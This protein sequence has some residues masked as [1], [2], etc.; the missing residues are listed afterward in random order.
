MTERKGEFSVNGQRETMVQLERLYHWANVIGIPILLLLALSGDERLAAAWWAV[1]VV[2]S[3]LNRRL[4][5]WVARVLGGL[6]SYAVALG[7]LSLGIA[8]ILLLIPL[9]LGT[10]VFFFIAAAYLWIS[11]LVAIVQEYQTREVA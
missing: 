5:G 1:I 10:V 6:F 2:S 3:L 9:A 11:S 7:C 8:G 4:R